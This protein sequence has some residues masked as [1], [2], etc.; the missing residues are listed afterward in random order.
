MDETQAYCAC[1]TVKYDPI[2]C[3]DGSLRER[4]RC[5]ECG[6]EFTKKFGVHD[7][8]DLYEDKGHLATGNVHCAVCGERV[9]GPISCCEADGD[10]G[11]VSKE[12]AAEI[13]KIR[14]ETTQDTENKS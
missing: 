9:G 14:K 5:A 13:R 11:L 1:L 7:V 3:G 2:D 8:S 6:M 4:W 10:F 12:R